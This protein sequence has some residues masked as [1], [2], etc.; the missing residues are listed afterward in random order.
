M[1]AAGGAA[2]TLELETG[3][4][5]EGFWTRMAEVVAGAEGVETGGGGGGGAA[6]VV[7]TTADEDDWG[8]G[9]TG[10]VL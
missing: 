6:G 4:G 5:V 7:L 1:G 9:A 3:E 2:A 8:G 10:V